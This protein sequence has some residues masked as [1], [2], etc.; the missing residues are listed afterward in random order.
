MLEKNF[1]SSASELEVVR[2]E[3]QAEIAGLSGLN[4][5]DLRA[6]GSAAH[7]PQPETL[8]SQS[9]VTVAMEESPLAPGDDGGGGRALPSISLRMMGGESGRG[10]GSSKDGGGLGLGL[11]HEDGEAEEDAGLCSPPSAAS[12]KRRGKVGRR[13]MVRTYTDILREQ[14]RS[15]LYWQPATGIAVDHTEE[16]ADII[17]ASRRLA[18]GNSHRQGPRPS[19]QDRSVVCGCLAGRHD[20]DYFAVFDGHGSRAEADFAAWYV[21]RCTAHELSGL[22]TVNLRQVRLP[23]A[24]RLD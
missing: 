2:S 13:L 16:P 4:L 19:Q 20:T 14:A 12:T 8:E 1:R 24:T 23:A 17:S 21:H 7:E 10:D 5:E 22:A 9:A 3:L 11:G 15:A 6:S 18:V